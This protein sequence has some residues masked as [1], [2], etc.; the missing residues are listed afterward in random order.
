[1]MRKHGSVR[2]Q[3]LAAPRDFLHGLLG[4]VFAPILALAGVIGLLYLVTRRLPALREV[5]E[6]DGVQRKAIVLDAPLEARAS[7]ARYAGELRGA[8]LEIKAR[9]QSRLKP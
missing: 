4:G 2:A 5:A 8:L 1:M 3:W 6:G 7:W 9:A